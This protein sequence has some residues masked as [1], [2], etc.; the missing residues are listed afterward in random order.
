MRPARRAPAAQGPGLVPGPGQGLRRLAA[1]RQHRSPGAGRTRTPTRG[2][3]A[4]A[5]RRRRLET[6]R[7][8]AAH[9]CLARCRHHRARPTRRTTRTHPDPRRRLHPADLFQPPRRPRPQHP[10]P[11]RTDQRRQPP[12]KVP[13]SPS[14]QTTPP[15]QARVGED[16]RI[17]W[18][19]PTGHT[20]PE[21][22]PDLRPGPTNTPQPDPHN[23]PGIGPDPPPDDP[24]PF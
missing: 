8:P 7:L 11:A 12:I 19:T 17:Q 6:D 3:R 21:H 5:D 23:G 16:G 4:A 24:A 20:Y 22:Q 14:P 10:L 18:I 15:W 9:R 1:R 2:C 13:T